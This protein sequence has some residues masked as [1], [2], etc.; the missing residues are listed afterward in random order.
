MDPATAIARTR[1]RSGLSQV[2]LAR[3]AGTSQPTLSAYENGAKAPSVRVLE[4]LLGAAGARL[5]VAEL[6]GSDA[7][8]PERQAATANVLRDVIALAQALPARHADELGYPRLP[9]RRP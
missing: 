3:R 8:A 7:I 5:T 1:R 4:R 6:P 2:E 9:D